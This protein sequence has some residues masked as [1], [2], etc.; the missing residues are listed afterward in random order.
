MKRLGETHYLLAGLT[1]RARVNT[2]TTQAPPRSNTLVQAGTAATEVILASAK[3]N[4][5]D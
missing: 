2:S 1:T 4:K 5:A 3:T